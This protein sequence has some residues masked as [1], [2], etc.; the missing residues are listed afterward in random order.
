[1]RLSATPLLP[2]LAT[3]AARELAERYG[4]DPHAADWCHY[5]RLV[6]FT[7]RKPEHTRAD[8]RRHG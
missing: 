1:V 2:D 3:A 8:G 4:G 6:G 5:G 7:N